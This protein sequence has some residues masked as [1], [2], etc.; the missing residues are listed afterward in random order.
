MLPSDSCAA[1]NRLHIIHFGI[2]YPRHHVHELQRIAA[3]IAVYPH[4]PIVGIFDHDSRP[5]S[6]TQKH[7]AQ[8][9]PLHRMPDPV[10]DTGRYK[11]VLTRHAFV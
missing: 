1:D 4:H 8:H 2:I 3:Y 7:L 5:H 9:D 11:P 6:I 10:S